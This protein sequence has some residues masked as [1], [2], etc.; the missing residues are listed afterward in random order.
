MAAGRRRDWRA[1]AGRLLIVVAL[2]TPALAAPVEG[3]LESVVFG[4]GDTIRGVAERYLKDADLWP[5]ILELSGIASPAELRAGAELKI[6]VVQVA[7]ADEALA[8][9]L[10]A[11][12]KATAE[13]ARIFAPV[14]IGQAIDNRDTAVESRGLGAWA[15]VVTYAGLATGFAD[16]ALEISVAQRDRAAEAVVS[17]AQGSVEG[18]APDQPRWSPRASRDILVEFERLRTLS[19]STAQVTFRDLSRLRLNANS[20]AVIQRMRSDP[21]TGGEVTK[22]SLVNGDFYA[23]LNQLGDRTNFEVTVPGVETATQSA[24][25]W[26]KHDAEGSRFTNYDAAALEITR[27]AERIS[28]GENE[29]AVLPNAGEAERTRVLAQTGLAAPADGTEIFDPAVTL[30]WQPS[31]G[32]EGYWLE[33][34]ADP[35][36]NTMQASEWGLRDTS[37]ALDGLAPGDHY[38]RVSSLDRLG[39]PGVRSLSWRF[40]IVDDTTPPFVAV[41]TPKEAEIVTTA[42]VAVSGEAEAGAALTVNGAA[43]PVAEGGRFSTTITPTVGANTLEIAAVDRA[44]NRTERS[45]GFTYA[46]LGAVSISLDPGLPRDADGRLLSASP[47]LAIAGA[48]SAGPGAGLRVATADGGIAVQTLVDAGGAFHFTVPATAA[49]ADYRVEILGPDGAVAG[50]LALAVRQDATPPE[51]ALDLP[52]RAT[53]NA[54]L[55][56]TG[57]ADGAVAVTVNGSP[58]RLEAGR[59][60]ATATLAPGPNGIEIVATDAVGNV[61][62]KR[63]ETIFDVDPPAIGAARADRPAGAAGP[64]EIVVEAR[65][66]SGLRQAAP[67][68]LDVGGVERR[69]FLR[70]E[71]AAG[72]CRET[73]PPEAGALRLIEVTVEDYAGN[74]AKHRE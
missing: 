68:I 44:G 1:A 13:G 73:L 9:S 15:E 64:I 22:V 37:H 67:F 45:R 71:D 7:A 48:S 2:S 57:T 26:V 70:C 4:P 62:I 16:K 42:E 24:D 52:P 74:A 28:I 6:P 18:R 63:V 61:A 17:D 53:A 36:F 20:N 41:A 47:E 8:F 69:G 38:W 39:L 5:Q 14:E 59:F 32:A 30:A 23:L 49:G 19:A 31:E 29:G 65:D 50:T 72:V 25:F 21:L 60:A 34:A 58:A 11:I 33:V 43:V 35:G 27:G 3:P 56:V 55:D 66:A 10:A 51:I 46:P 12:Q 54:W 40:R